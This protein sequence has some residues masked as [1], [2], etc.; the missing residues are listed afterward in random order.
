MKVRTGREPITSGPGISGCLPSRLGFSI[1]VGT[2]RLLE[3]K[4]KG[5]NRAG[6]TEMD[7]VWKPGWGVSA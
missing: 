6:Q 7:T 1:G 5:L 2:R 4:H 3:E